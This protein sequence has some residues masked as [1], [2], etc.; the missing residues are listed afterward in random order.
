METESDATRELD[1]VRREAVTDRDGN[2]GDGKQGVVATGDDSADGNCIM[3][4]SLKE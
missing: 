4:F 2:D 1:S 3:L